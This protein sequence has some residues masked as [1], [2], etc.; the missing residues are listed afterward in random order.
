[1][2]AK[3]LLSFLLARL[4]DVDPVVV[5]ALC[6]LVV[7]DFITGV[8]RA[9]RNGGA[10]SITSK[11]FRKTFEKVALYAAA[12]LIAMVVGNV[13]GHSERLPEFLRSWLLQAPH[14]VFA[15]VMVLEGGSILE[16]IRGKSFGVIV[17]E[18]L[19]PVVLLL[20]A[21]KV[22]RKEGAGL[23]DPTDGEK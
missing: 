8:Y 17:K 15:A 19:S 1:M 22:V 9:W 14:Y 6:G 2:S 20:R 18:F 4:L 11:G 21:A 16:N 5:V 7:V 3:T 10:E 12:I 23:A 13:C